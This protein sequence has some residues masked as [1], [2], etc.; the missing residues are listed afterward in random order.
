MPFADAD[1]A[2]NA[3]ADADDDDIEIDVEFTDAL[4][5]S[6]ATTVS[7][8]NASIRKFCKRFPANVFKELFLVLIFIN[9]NSE[10]DVNAYYFRGCIKMAME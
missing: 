2:A 7:K 9:H 10:T 3:D 1:A 8:F 4:A 5:F 6:K